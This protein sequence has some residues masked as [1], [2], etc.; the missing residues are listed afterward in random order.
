MRAS[1][2]LAIGVTVMTMDTKDSNLEAH[3]VVIS[4]MAIG[5]CRFRIGYHVI[6]SKRQIKNQYFV[7]R[8]RSSPYCDQLEGF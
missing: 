1:V 3:I 7:P 8:G 4:V 2:I 5:Y 6:K